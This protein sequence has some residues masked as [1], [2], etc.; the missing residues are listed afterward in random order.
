MGLKA[1]F[2]MRDDG[3]ED[4]DN[5]GDYNNGNDDARQTVEHAEYEDIYA[6]NYN[7]I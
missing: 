1:V 2:Q 5:D 7:N 3:D 6:S 4:D